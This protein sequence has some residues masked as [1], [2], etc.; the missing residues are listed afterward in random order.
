MTALSSSI[1]PYHCHPTTATRYPATATVTY[2][3]RFFFSFFPFFSFFSFC[4]ISPSILPQSPPNYHQNDRA[5][6]RNPTV[7]QPPSHCHS[8]PRPTPPST[9]RSVRLLRAAKMSASFKR[10]KCRRRCMPAPELGCVLI[11]KL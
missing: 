8:L 6:P 1:Q 3:S 4:T 10:I 11:G 9:H 2:K 5:D 7:P